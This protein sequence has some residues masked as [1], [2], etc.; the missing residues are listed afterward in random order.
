M[1][2]KQVGIISAVSAYI[3]WGAL[4]VF[5]ELLNA[6]PAMD[7]LAYRVVFSIVTICSEVNKLDYF[8]SV[9]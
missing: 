5:W 6:V 2:N 9:N 8:Y 4:G 3:L 1:E 7:T